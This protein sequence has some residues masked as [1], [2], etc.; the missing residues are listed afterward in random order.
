MGLFL[1]FVPL[2]ALLFGHA[3]LV[4][5]LAED[6]FFAEDFALFFDGFEDVGGGVVEV[7]F[8]GEGGGDAFFDELHDLDVADVGVLGDGDVEVVADLES[9][10]GLER[11]LGA[12][13][14]SGLAGFGGEGPGLVEADGPEPLVESATVRHERWALGAFV[15]TWLSVA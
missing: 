14:F 5:F 3:T 1:G 10:G 11:F 8:A 6:A 12:F 2:A 15:L 4:S 13:D 7:G 9:G